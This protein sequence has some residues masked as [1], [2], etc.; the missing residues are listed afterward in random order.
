M[1]GRFVFVGALLLAGIPAALAQGK[2]VEVVCPIDGER[3]KY[4]L[5]PERSTNETYLDQRSVDP[6]LPWPYAKCPTSGFVIYRSNFPR[7]R[8]ARL[9]QYVKTDEYRQLAKV[10]TTRYLEAVMRR[11]LN[12]SPYA[13]AYA[14]LQATWEAWGNPAL[15]KQYAGEALAAYDAIALETL[16]EIR[17]RILKRMISVELARRLGQFDSARERLLAMRDSAELS[18]PFLQRI[19]ELQLKLVRAKDSGPHKIP[20]N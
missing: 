4:Q 7:G 5:A 19:V 6:A 3:F 1:M 17:Q 14:L 20:Y 13:V 15:Y 8:I 16:P 10:H 11:Y 12:D 2:T 18:T 9:Q